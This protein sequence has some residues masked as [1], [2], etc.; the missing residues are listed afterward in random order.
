MR[1]W[2]KVQ[3]GYTA[4]T[5]D[6]IPGCDQLIKTFEDY[7]KLLTVWYAEIRKRGTRYFYRKTLPSKKVGKPTC[8]KA[9]P[10]PNGCSSTP[11]WAW[12]AAS[13]WR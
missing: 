5:L 12:P 4:Q 6:Q 11:R 10:A 3:G 9:K 2:F 8:V 7:D 1:V 13:R